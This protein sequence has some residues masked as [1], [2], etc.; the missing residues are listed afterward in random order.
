M[1]RLVVLISALGCACSAGAPMKPGP[2]PKP[3]H[4]AQAAPLRVVAV[5]PPPAGG[6][7]A[8]P[9][10]VAMEQEL[11][12]YFAALPKALSPRPYF[13]AYQVTDRHVAS[14]AAAL[15]A[16]VSS[17]RGSSRSLDVDLRV[18][19]HRLDNT[20]NIRGGG[21]GRR[22]RRV[23]WT[24]PLD[25]DPALL[26]PTLWWA[27]DK[28]HEAAVEAYLQVKGNRKVKTRPEDDS[29][30]FSKEQPV[31]YLERPGALELDAPAWEQK[32]RAYSALFRG[33]RELL[34]SGVTLSTQVVNRYLTNS[35][36]T[37]TQ[38]SRTYVRLSAYGT[39]RSADGMDL[40]RLDHVDA[41][42]PGQLPPE[43]EVRR[44]IKRV[45][46]D[47]LALR[48]A[49]LAA[50]YMGPAILDG[51]AAAIFFHETFGHRVEGH[52]QKDDDEGQTFA[53]KVGTRIMPAFIDVYDD[54][55]IS[56]LN[57]V[58]L[59]GFYRVDDEG[60]RTRRVSLIK[61]GVLGGFLMSRSPVRGFAHSNG[62]GRRSEG[63]AVV[64]RQGNLIVH[65]TR[66]VRPD[67]LKRRLIAEVRRQK[68]PYGLRFTQVT[69]GYTT[70]SRR[71][72]QGFKVRPVMVY[73]VYP[74]GREQLIRGVNIEGTPLTT[75]AQI[76]AAGDDMTVD[77]GNCGAESG[78][79]PVSLASPSLLVARIEVARVTSQNEKPLILPPPPLPVGEG[80]AR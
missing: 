24:M 72:I 56:V 71:S 27:T 45:I 37:R 63:Y 17:E 34:R 9:P 70:T 38:T 51:R 13:L 54:P 20:H 50:P 6:A 58:T 64:S 49:P 35:E 31:R 39:A 79:V 32:I 69:S 73:R 28:A 48:K 47:L 75:M 76:L 46:D 67:E 7:A 74:D 43:A 21:Q 10:L 65:P 68:K 77:N 60:V 14:I 25:A 42:T 11:A 40:H 62:H 66:T 33:Q 61:G 29:D 3:G 5:R 26:K 2:Q 78:S 15:G 41:G 44:M 52:R 53:K 80:G 18:G 4:A 59:N 8:A 19:S 12:R 30:D 23:R 22:A 57:G 55:T 16:L 1:K 36:G